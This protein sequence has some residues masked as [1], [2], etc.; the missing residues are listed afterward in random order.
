MKIS[1]HGACREVTGS[2]HLVD[3]GQTRF[4]VDCGLFQGGDFAAKKNF[5]AFDFDPKSIDF[6]ILTHAHLDHCGRLP[7]LCQEGFS[8]PIYCTPPTG[9]FTEIMLI[10]SARVIF[11]EALAKNE[12]PLYLDQDVKK[13]IGQFKTIDYHQ[14]T[15]LSADVNL[16]FFDAGHILGSAFVGLTIGR[17]LKKKTIVFSGDLG[18]PPVPLLPATESIGGADFVV[19]ESTYGGR[20][21]EPASLR[22]DMLRDI[23][24]QTIGRGGILMIPAFSLERTQELLYELNHLVENKEVPSVPVYV[25]SP[26]AIKATAVYRKYN[27]LFNAESKKLI[28]AGDDIFEFPKLKYVTSPKLSKALNDDNKSKVIIAGSGMCNGGRIIFHLQHHLGNAKNQLLIIGY[29]AEGTTGRLLLDGARSVDI[30]H[31]RISV[32]AKITA[33]GAYSAHA[34]QPK[35]L[36]WVK[37]ISKPK[38]KQVFLVHGEYKATLMVA[39][40]LKQKLNI[41][42]VVPE[43]GQIYEI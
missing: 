43:Y 15:K 10:D 13:M 21:H 28:K 41:K 42:A 35:L 20:I 31:Q 24:R 34:D 32:K 38:P 16:T 5:E 23:F 1:F 40:G 12:L 19:L 6:V 27:S 2:C 33:I 29:Q 9:D 18:N 36:H 8:G 30:R 25:D 11:E 14:T 22:H 39:D 17:G 3:T 4:L 26:L 7:K 37:Q